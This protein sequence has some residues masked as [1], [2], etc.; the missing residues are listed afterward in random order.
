MQLVVS[1]SMCCQIKI[2]FQIMLLVGSTK[3]V[4]NCE[5]L[6]LLQLIILEVLSRNMEVL[7]KTWINLK[8]IIADHFYVKF[9]LKYKKLPIF[10]VRNSLVFCMKICLLAEM[11]QGFLSLLI[12]DWCIYLQL[13]RKVVQTYLRWPTSSVALTLPR[14]L[15]FTS[16]W[17]SVEILA[18]CT[19]L[20]RVRSH[21][22]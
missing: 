7:F 11:G 18:V 22:V 6:S 8:I 10:K 15:S 1:R 19:P 21:V 3:Y 12:P 16:R 9:W 5:F 20:V 13:H 14:A 2:Y 4:S 17:L